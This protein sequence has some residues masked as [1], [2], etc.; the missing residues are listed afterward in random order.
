MPGNAKWPP[1]T[2]LQDAVP[3][4]LNSFLTNE[5][6]RRVSPSLA[7]LQILGQVLSELT[8]HLAHAKG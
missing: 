7:R 6:L 3:R 4:H 1:H 2:V 8:K 5:A